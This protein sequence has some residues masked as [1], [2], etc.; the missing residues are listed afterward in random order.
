MPRHISISQD[1]NN[2]GQTHTFQDMKTLLLAFQ[3]LQANPS[4]M[5]NETTWEDTKVTAGECGLYFCINEYEPVLNQGVLHEETQ[6]SWTD[7]VSDSYTLQKGGGPSESIEKVVP[8][9]I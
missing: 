8:V 2:P 1:H 5:N 7:K 4:W 3:Y 9:T 6:K